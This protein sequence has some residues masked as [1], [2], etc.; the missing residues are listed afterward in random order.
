MRRVLALGLCVV[1]LG[2]W[3]LALADAPAG[4]NPDRVYVDTI[5]EGLVRTGVLTQEQADQLKSQAAAAAEQAAKEA[6]PAAP[7]KP[8]EA[9]KKKAWYD[10]VKVSGYI[11]GRFQY[12]P[13]YPNADRKTHSSEFL[14]RRARFKFTFE[15]NDFTQVVVE[16]D[17]GEGKVE[18]RD[19]YIQRWMGAQK[20]SSFRLGQQKIPFGFE[21]PQSSSVRLPL[22]RNY[23][24]ATMFPGERDTG[25]VLF[26]TDPDDRKL[27]D[28]SR[29]ASFG[30]G[31]YGNLA[32]GFLNGQGRNQPEVNSSKHFVIRVTKPLSLGDEGRYMELGA[33]YWHGTYFSKWDSDAPGQNFTDELLGFHL[34]VEPKPFGLQAE[35]YTGET[36]GGDVD[37]WYAMGMLRT[38]TKGTLFVRHEDYEGHR[39]GKGPSYIFDRSRTAIGYA[40]QIDERNRLTVEYDMEDVDP[41][42][43]KPGYDNDF[44]GIQWMTTY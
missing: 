25:L 14:V 18:A 28:A 35:Y 34:F 9:P 5:L 29:K 36:E 6:P 30:V 22:E 31:D 17:V 13:D 20:V 8:A 2:A 27:F 37:G 7:E 10:S 3:G 44:F 11:Q 32:I 38:G 43:N 21:T 40:H 39:K 15:P 24:A 41:A 19:V 16:P 33:S 23:L 12:Y 1:F 42:N 26:Y 4:Q